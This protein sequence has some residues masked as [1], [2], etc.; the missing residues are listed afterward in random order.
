MTVQNTVLTGDALELASVR[1][2]SSATGLSF[3]HNL[4]QDWTR[5]RLLHRRQQRFDHRQHVRRQRQ[6]RLQRRHVVRRYRTTASADRPA[7]DVGGYITSATFDIGTVV[8]DNTYSAAVAQPISVYVFGRDGQVVN[9][10]DTA[11]NFHLEYHSGTATVH[12]GAGSD[13]ISYSDDGAGV[14]INLAA[15][16]ATG[17]GGTTTF[18]S[19]ENAIGGGGNDTITGNGGANTLI[20]D[21]GNDTLDG[22]AGADTLI[23]GTGNDTYV[24]DNAGDVDHRGARARA[25]TRSQSTVSYTLGANVEN[26]TLTGS[27]DING[28]GNALANII[29]GNSGNNTLDGGAGADT[30]IGGLGNDTYVVD[31]A[32]DVV[33]ARRSARAPTRCSRRS[34]TRSAPMSRT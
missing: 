28:T 31:N 29:T 11:T 26:L 25:P 12:G 8:H 4:V 22:G 14:T 32:G 21:A 6:W 15:G 23:G 7:A 1:H 17:A 3:D 9:G 2:L 5:A 20:G 13:A 16:T 27:A 10:T 19:I 24:V 34:P 33:D 30:L 18:T